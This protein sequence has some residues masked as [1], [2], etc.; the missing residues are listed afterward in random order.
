MCHLVASATKPKIKKTTAQTVRTVLTVVLLVIMIPMLIVNGTLIV[1]NMI[2]P[3]EIPTFIGLFPNIVQTPSMEG[4]AED[5]FNAGDLI[6]CRK[7]DARDIQVGDVISF[8]DPMG[9]GTSVL[10]HRV[11]E[12]KQTDRG[13][14][15][16]TKGDA[17]VQADSVWV[18]EGRLVGRYTG[19]RF[20]GLG[21]LAAVMQTTKGLLLLTVF[22]LTL[23]LIIDLLYYQLVE[24]KKKKALEGV[25]LEELEK[26]RNEQTD[27][28]AA[29]LAEETADEPI[30]E[31]E[32]I[33][34][35]EE[36]EGSTRTD[37][38]V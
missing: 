23:L 12:I 15:F 30:E 2:W 10:T 28:T 7:A 3:N 35:I 21:D 34:E 5:S 25:L 26:L 17:N 29:D 13:I 6:I 11:V 19:I 20:W 32:E 24:R 33:D 4:D 18:A 16:R 1:K 8:Y 36:A 38:D 14:W 37:R 22:P 27:Q 31:I 9:N